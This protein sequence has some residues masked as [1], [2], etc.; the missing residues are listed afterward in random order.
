M[1][2]HLNIENYF[3]NVPLVENGTLTGEMTKP[4][5][6]G[7]D[8]LLYAK[9]FEAEKG[10]SLKDSCYYSDSI[11]DLEAMAGFGCPV[12]VNPDPLL[13]REAQKLGWKIIDFKIPPPAL[14]KGRG[15]RDVV[16]LKVL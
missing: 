2:R 7:K 9:K 5:C 6:Y 3:C 14:K 1:S 16:T 10:I 8:K 11:T 4:L 12:A 15:K 13:R